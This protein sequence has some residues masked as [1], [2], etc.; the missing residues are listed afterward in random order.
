VITQHVLIEGWW[1]ALDDSTQARLRALAE[2]DFLPAELALDLQM[3]GVSVIA[4]GTVQS[5]QG[6]V[7]LYEQP[8]GLRQLLRH[9]DENV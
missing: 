2:D 7:A 6:Y 1:D 8:D 3:Q 4:V 9:L 5:A